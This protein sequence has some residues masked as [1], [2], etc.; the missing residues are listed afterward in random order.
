MWPRRCSIHIETRQKSAASRQRRAG[1]PLAILT[2]DYG[3]GIATFI[4]RY[5]CDLLPGATAVIGRASV[6]DTRPIS[7]RAPGP[8]L[9]LAGIIG[10]RLRRQVAH[11][12]FKQVGVHLDRIAIKRFWKQHKVQVVLGQYLDFSLQ[13]LDLARESGLRFFVRA[14]GDDFLIRPQ[15]PRWRA[16]YLRYA[17]ADGIVSNSRAGRDALVA[18]GLDASKIRVLHYGIDVPDQP[19]PRGRPPEIRCICVG[20]VVPQKAPI[21]LLDS[22]RRAAEQVPSLRL[23]Y[24]GDGSLMPAVREFLQAFHLHDK[25]TVHGVQNND[26]VLRLLQQA[27]IYIQ[28]S[29]WEGLGIA[30]LEA[31]AHALPVVATATGGILETVVDST[32]G[33]LVDPRDSAAMADRIVSLARDPD[34]RCRLGLAGWRRAREHFTW[35]RERA[36]L[37][38]ILGLTQWA[39]SSPQT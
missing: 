22:F 32:T 19:P 11:G 6:E 15:D 1:C 23:D 4:R 2:P 25:V 13:W 20:R 8:F 5:A 24:V 17:Q 12:A 35:E 14:H 38:E 37:L 33:Y 27:D 18:L 21:L 16:E 31:M 7:W 26:A 10:G 3:L 9:D 36:Q 39:Q 30:I 34:L 29:V 28:H